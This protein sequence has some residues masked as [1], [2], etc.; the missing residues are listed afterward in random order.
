VIITGVRYVS[1]P[2]FSRLAE[3][4]GSLSV[5]VH[6]SVPLVISIV[7]PV[8]VVTADLAPALAALSDDPRRG[9]C[10]DLLNL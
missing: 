5:A 1:I 2:A 3:Q 8:A 9:A 7:L 4:K 6:R 10:T